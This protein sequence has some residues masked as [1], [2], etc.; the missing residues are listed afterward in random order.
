MGNRKHL[1]T[2]N[3]TFICMSEYVSVY[4]TVE[5]VFECQFCFEINRYEQ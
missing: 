5:F 3:N 1:N 4:F 2:E